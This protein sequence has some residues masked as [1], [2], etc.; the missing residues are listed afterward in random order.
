M[1]FFGPETTMYG[2]A[3]G[4][5]AAVGLSLMGILGSSYILLRHQ[6]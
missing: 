1:N 4:L 6:S 2:K 5:E 3:K